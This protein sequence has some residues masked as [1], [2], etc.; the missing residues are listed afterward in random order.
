MSEEDYIKEKVDRTLDSSILF[1][2]W[3]SELKSSGIEVFPLNINSKKI[4]FSGCSFIYKNKKYV[5]SKIGK[6]YSA[7]SLIKRGLLFNP[8]TDKDIL[9]KLYFKFQKN[10]QEAFFEKLFKSEDLDLDLKSKIKKES[11]LKTLFEVNGIVKING[12]KVR[13]KYYSSFDFSNLYSQTSI[14]SLS[15]SC[16]QMREILID[17]VEATLTYNNRNDKKP[18]LITITSKVNDFETIFK[19]GERCVFLAISSLPQP[20]KDVFLN[21]FKF[22]FDSKMYSAHQ[23]FVDSLSGNEIFKIERYIDS[24]KYDS[25]VINPSFL[26]I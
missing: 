10:N 26:D 9:E 19:N 15:P 8:V 7:P 18:C 22:N 6:N 14:G 13:I 21:L 23:L 1:Y 5:A 4:G 11:I 20:Y 16:I 24:I 17:D 2:D 12:N 3:V 25:C